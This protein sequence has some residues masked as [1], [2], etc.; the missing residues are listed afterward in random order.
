MATVFTPKSYYIPEVSIEAFTRSIHGLA[1]NEQRMFTKGHKLFRDE[2]V[3]SPASTKTRDGLGPTFNARSCEGCHVRDGRAGATKPDGSLA[4]GI[5]FRLSVPGKDTDGGPKPVPAYGGQLQ[6]FG[7]LG[8]PGEGQVKVTYTDVPGQ[9]ADG[10]P[11]VLH[12]P[13]YEFVNL[14]FGPMPKDV[15]VSPRTAPAMIGLGLLEAVSDQAILALADPEDRNK[16]GISGRANIVWNVEKQA[17]SVG[18]FGWKANQPNLKQQTA[19]AFQGD[20]GIT[21][22]MFPVENCMPAQ[23]ACR[24]AP[25]GG[26]PELEPSILDNIVF[27]G[28]VLGVP[29]PRPNEAAKAGEKL[30]ASFQC[31]SCHLPHLQSDKVYPIEALRDKDVQAFTD[32]LLHDMGPGLADNRED[33]LAS[34]TEWRTTPLWG[35]GLIELV[36]KHSQYLHDGR[37]R[38]LEEAILWHGGEA[39]AAK[40][41][42]R[43]APQEQ[44]HQ[45]L[46]FL[47]AL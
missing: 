6:P 39:E 16:D 15:K 7:V 22:H 21:S 20:I 41:K 1:F 40:E 35:I 28:K 17:T 5:L 32:L 31:A 10:T 26:K 46:E 34:G 2:W 11:Y 8:V 36:N 13:K 19:G 29:E 30:F 24:K 3:T 9:Y 27:Y 18:R 45:L 43:T 42:F 14:A 23:T 4:T 25:N 12:Q 33:F 38:S 44:R 47:K 37:A